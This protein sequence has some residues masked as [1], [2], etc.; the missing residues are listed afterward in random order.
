MFLVPRDDMIQDLA[1]AAPDPA[2]AD[3][4]LPWRLYAGS[5]GLQPG[6]LQEGSDSGI[7][8]RISVKDGVSIGAGLGEGFPQLLNYP[9]HSRMAGDVAMQDPASAVLHDEKARQ[10]LKRHRRHG[11]E[12]E[13]DDRLAVILREGK[14]RFRWVTATTNSPQINAQKAIQDRP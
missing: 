11:E 6:C 12:V 7:E 14:P 9:L 1:T 13:R 4:V 5:F 8:R 2:L 3:T 10:Q